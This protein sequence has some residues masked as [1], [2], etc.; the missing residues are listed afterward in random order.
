MAY[1]THGSTDAAGSNSASPNYK[2]VWIPGF[3]ATELRRILI[4]QPTEVWNL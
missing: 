1:V 3:T 4:M 2:E